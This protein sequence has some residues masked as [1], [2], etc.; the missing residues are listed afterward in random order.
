MMS[1]ILTHSVTTGDVTYTLSIVATLHRTEGSALLEWTTDTLE[2]DVVI[3][4]SWFVHS[5][6]GPATLHV[7]IDDSG[8]YEGPLPFCDLL[9]RLMRGLVEQGACWGVESYAAQGLEQELS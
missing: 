7:D 2:G 4:G 9:D 6:S 5:E 1:A 8:D 3:N